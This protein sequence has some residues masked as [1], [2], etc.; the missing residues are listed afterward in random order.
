M[1]LKNIRKYAQIFSGWSRKEVDIA[2][3]MLFFLKKVNV[4][5]EEFKG[6]A[7]YLQ[8]ESFYRVKAR[9]NIFIMMLEHQQKHSK[10][11]PECGAV[12]NIEGVNISKCTQIADKKIQSVWSCSDRKGCGHQI[13]NTKS[14]FFYIK[15]RNR[16]FFKTIEGMTEKEISEL[17]VDRTIH[18]FYAGGGDSQP[19][20]RG[21][22]EK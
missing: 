4:T 21:C 11:C 22:R 15:Q 18:K 16:N 10:K 12:M 3:Q 13:W 9:Q 5:L 20:T 2:Y 14:D 17:E 19:Q 8:E 7:S 1:N 6:Y